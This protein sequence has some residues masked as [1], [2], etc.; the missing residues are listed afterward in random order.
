MKTIFAGIVAGCIL[1]SLAT[2]QDIYAA[3]CK[4]ASPSGNLTVTT[5][6]SFNGTVNG[7]DSGTGGQNTANLSLAPGGSLTIL[8]GQT[9]A[10]GSISLNGGSVTIQNGGSIALGIPL[11]M[12]DADADGYPETTT[13][14]IG[15]LP[16]VNGRRRNTQTTIHI[17]DGN[18]AYYCPDTYNPSVPCNYCFNGALANQLDGQDLFNQCPQF[19]LCNGQGSCSLHAKKVFISSQNYKGNLGGLPGADSSCQTLAT[20]ASLS[21]T[22][23]AWLSDNATSAASRLTH[24]VYPYILV[25]EMTK[26]ADSWS[27]LT[28]STLSAAISKTENGL[29][30]LTGREVWTNTKPDGSQAGTT[31]QFTCSNW[32][33]KAGS[34]N[35]RY[36]I[37]TSYTSG[38]WSDFASDGCN[39]AKYLYCFEQ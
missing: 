5:V 7:V 8:S 16:P 28:T 14:Y 4:D 25:D 34:G 27:N 15:Q 31:N 37:H 9:I 29:T 21:G 10:V 23:K 12:K 20:T 24:S 13:Q 32:T 33:S 2:M 3:D 39:K 11:W 22:W 36:G 35:G 6:C 30:I 1:F 18:D 38:Q 19:Y 26:I 17:A